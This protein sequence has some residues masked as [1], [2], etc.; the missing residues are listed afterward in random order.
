MQ[1][2]EFQITVRW[3][4]LIFIKASCLVIYEAQA[5]VTHH[6]MKRLFSQDQ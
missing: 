3:L 2:F 5:A 1:T 6:V 4:K